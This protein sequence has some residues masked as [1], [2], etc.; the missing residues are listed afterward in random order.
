M[1]EKQTVLEMIEDIDARRDRLMAEEREDARQRRVDLAAA[2]LFANGTELTAKEA[3]AAADTLEKEREAFLAARKGPAPRARTAQAWELEEARAEERERI[4]TWAEEAGLVTQAHM[5][6]VRHIA[7]A[8]R[9]G[10]GALLRDAHASVSYVRHD[11][12]VRL[13][14]RVMEGLGIVGGGSVFVDLDSN[15]AVIESDE[16]FLRRLGLQEGT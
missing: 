10:A 3:Y 15:K 12:V 2:R 5:E 13:S 7:D 11:G 9:A 1:N 16:T 8:I 4:A 14:P 6:V